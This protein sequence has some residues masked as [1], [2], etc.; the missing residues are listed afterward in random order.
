M[1]IE[2]ASRGPEAAR[3]YQLSVLLV[4]IA[5]V[6]A[7]NGVVVPVLPLY[8]MEFGVSGALVGML[9]TLFGVGRLVANIPA[10]FLS[11]RFGRRPLLAAGPVLIGIGAVGAALTDNFEMLLFSRF[12]QG[13][14]AGVYMTT[15]AATLVQLTAPGRR[16]H[17]MGLYQGFMLMGASIGPAIGGALAARFGNDAPFWFYAVLALAALAL[18]SFGFKEPAAVN[19]VRSEADGPPITL[20]AFLRHPA[21]ALLCAVTFWIFFTRTAAQWL[22]MPLIGNE[23]FGLS[24]GLI[25]AAISVSSIANL[26]MVAIV[27]PAIQRVGAVSV[28]IVSTFIVAGALLLVALS[29]AVSLYW[30]AF[31]AY[32]IGAG[33]NAPAVAA[34]IADITPDNLVGPAMGVHRAIA[35]TGYVIGPILVGLVHDWTAFGYSGAIA[36]NA[37]FLMLTGILVWVGVLTGRFGPRRAA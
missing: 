12:V 19:A 21:F 8:A 17:I 27:G 9:I 34:A 11:E 15:S 25:G 18:V 26:A 6:Q 28:A 35:D 29:S 3:R 31:I 30:I 1:A 13:M 7:G 22:A 23:R 14:G 5:V 20:G 16:G 10:G 4:L 32:G 33:L 36:G 2:I 24:V 37:V